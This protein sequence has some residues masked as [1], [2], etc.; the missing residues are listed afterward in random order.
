MA[1]VIRQLKLDPQHFDVHVCV[2]AQHRQM[3]DQVLTLFNIQPDVDL[4]IMKPNQSLADL[5]AAI[6]SRLDAVIRDVRPDWVLAQGDTTTVMVASL[7]AFYNRSRFG[8]V[9]AGLRTGDKWQPFPEEINR[10][11]AG[12][13]ADMHFAPTDWSRQNLLHEHIPDSNIFVTGN[14]VID[15]L[16]WVA[17]QPYPEGELE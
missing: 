5:T 14:P 4:D 1:P 10:R 7:L 6:F 9:E 3:L 11:V 2:T 13:V 16:Q 12:V 15:A 17:R 8:H